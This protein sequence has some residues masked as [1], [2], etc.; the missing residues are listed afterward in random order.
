[1]KGT[2][3]NLILGNILS[4]AATKPVVVY[5]ISSTLTYI[6]YPAKNVNGTILYPVSRVYEYQTGY[7]RFDDASLSTSLDVKAGSAGLITAL[8]ALTWA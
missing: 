4:Q 3:R 1:M 7:T 5:E 8:G 2:E 6:I